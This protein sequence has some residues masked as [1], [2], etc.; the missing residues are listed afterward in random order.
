M[1]NVRVPA[2]VTEKEWS[3]EFVVPTE[4]EE[5]SVEMEDAEVD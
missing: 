3:W 5:V 2:A 4:P 1:E